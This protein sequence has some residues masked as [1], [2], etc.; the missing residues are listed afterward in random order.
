MEASRAGDNSAG[1]AGK[2]TVPEPTESLIDL[3]LPVSG[4]AGARQRPGL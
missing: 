3:A 1:H 4:D 2:V